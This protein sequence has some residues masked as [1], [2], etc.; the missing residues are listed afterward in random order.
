[1]GKIFNKILKSLDFNGR[2]WTV[3][4]FSLLLAFSIWLIHNL[5]L[6]YSEFIQ[7]PVRVQCEL[8]GHSD[9]SVN[10]DDVIARCQTS[11]YN[12]L[13]A[14]RLQHRKPLS[15]Q[16]TPSVLHSGGGEIFYMTSD[17]LQEYT[18][19]IFGENV[20]VE[21]FLKDT[22]FFR[23]PYETH[24][25]VPVYP[26]HILRYDPQYIGEGSMT[27]EPDSVVLYGEPA[28]LDNIGMV[29]T[30]PIRL[31]GINSNVHG[32]AKLEKVKGI[33]MSSESVHYSQGVTRFVEITSVVSIQSRNVPADKELMIYP[34]TAEVT[35][36][37]IFPLPSNPTGS[38]RF[39]VDY[40]D[41][42]N[43]L[44]GKCTVRT[45][46]LPPEIIGY[47]ITPR[48]FDCVVNERL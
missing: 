23:F 8:E 12:I 6:K 29:M 2:D 26:V 41:F 28:H 43:S 24:K 25:K 47:E 35:F 10:V 44:N 42:M 38:V 17:D 48:A 5:S 13:R 15:L 31:D 46:A 16:V 22:L 30:E 36:R 3:F 39:Y 4:L 1:M 21:Y 20:S 19:L 40:E 37:C 33:R 9:V 27:V 34:S 18:H 45:D 11:G 32:V 7:V 14:A